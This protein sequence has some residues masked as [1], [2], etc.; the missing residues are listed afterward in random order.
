MPTRLTFTPAAAASFAAVMLLSACGGGGDSTPASPVTPA[1]V[2]TLS[3]SYGAALSKTST[4]DGL[5]S[6][7]LQDAFD[8]KYLDAGNSKAAVLS[9]LA[10]EVAAAQVSPAFP[11]FPQVSL[12]N[13]TVTDCAREADK[14]AWVC[15]M[16][17]TVSNGDA[18]TTAAAFTTQVRFSDK[19][20][21]LGDQVATAG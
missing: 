1:V 15:S 2:A 3:D 8:A 7:T 16:T 5:A 12:S 18:D 10:G 19:L 20:R 11:G 13:V 9:A 17:A 14:S 6:A 21:L 4:T